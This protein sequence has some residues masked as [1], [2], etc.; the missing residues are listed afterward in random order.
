MLNCKAIGGTEPSPKRE[1]CMYKR[2]D[3][4]KNDEEK[5]SFCA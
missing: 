2:T 4:R 3:G 5:Y 1:R